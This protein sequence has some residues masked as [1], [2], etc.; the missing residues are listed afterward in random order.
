MRS[1]NLVSVLFAAGTLA[2]PVL[3]PRVL[4]TEHVVVTV[5]DYVTAG[6]QPPSTSST[7]TVAAASPDVKGNYVIVKP[8]SRHHHKAAAPVVV[9]T[10]EAVVVAPKST[11]TS[12]SAPAVIP[13]TSSSQAAPAPVTTQAPPADPKPAAGS[14]D[15]P[16]TKV[17]GLTSEDEVYKGLT[18]LHHNVHRS[19]HSV[20]ALEWNQTLADFAKESAKTCVW[21]HNL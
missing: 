7:L 17:A 11:S 9:S 6:A 15:L 1:A 10:P 4:V 14:S 5:T 20:P 8:H 13:P 3:D 12:T 19:N 21:G 16:K 2:T 18:L